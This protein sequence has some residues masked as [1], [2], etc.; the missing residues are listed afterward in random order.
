MLCVRFCFYVR[1]KRENSC[2]CSVYFCISEYKGSFV[3]PKIGLDNG[4]FIG[5]RGH[6]PK[7]LCWW[8]TGGACNPFL[9]LQGGHKPGKPGMLRDFSE[10]GKLRE[11]CATS[12]KNSNKQSIFS[13]SFKYLCK[14]AV[15]W[16]NRIISFSGSSD[17]AQ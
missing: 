11:F 13:L 7:Y 15:D 3:I 16:V 10:H 6:N 5:G 8:A 4:V 2:P 1:N 12:G 17:A 9:Y 14:T